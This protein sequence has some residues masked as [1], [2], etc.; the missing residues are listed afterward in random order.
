MLK[1]MVTAAEREKAPRQLCIFKLALFLPHRIVGFF[2]CYCY[3]N[4]LCEHLQANRDAN[5]QLFTCEKVIRQCYL[6]RAALL[7]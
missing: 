4:R 3:E 2:G 6:G 1:A 7:T 5:S